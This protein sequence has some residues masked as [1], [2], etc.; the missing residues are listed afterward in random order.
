MM[1]PRVVN[2]H[3][4]KTHLSKLLDEVRYGDEI[5]LAKYGKPYARLVRIGSPPKR[6]LGFLALE[7]PEKFCDPLPDEKLDAWE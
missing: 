3:E 6:A 4:A 1:L 5:I 2:V 7:V